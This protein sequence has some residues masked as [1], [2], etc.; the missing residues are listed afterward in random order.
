MTLVQYFVC[1][2]TYSFKL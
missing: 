1:C 2:I